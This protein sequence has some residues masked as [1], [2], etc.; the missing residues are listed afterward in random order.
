MLG[1]IAKAIATLLTYP[2][3]VMSK[4][5]SNTTFADVFTGGQESHAGVERVQIG[6]ERIR[7]YLQ[8][9]RHCGIVQRFLSE[10]LANNSELS[11]DVFA[12]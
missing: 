10:A 7:T 4:Y 9:R 5:I 1:A 3:Q 12:V 11:I 6:V 8:Q 2:Y